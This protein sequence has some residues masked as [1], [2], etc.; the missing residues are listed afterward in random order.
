[1]ATYGKWFIDASTG[2]SSRG[3]EID[4]VDMCA[5]ELY[6]ADWFEWDGSQMI[7][8]NNIRFQCVDDIMC[9]CKTLDITGF[10]YHQSSRNGLYTFNNST[11]NGRNRFL[12]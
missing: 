8:S 11:L 10:S 2:S 1:M 12:T 7:E 5:E 4:S 9:S 3:V 6:N